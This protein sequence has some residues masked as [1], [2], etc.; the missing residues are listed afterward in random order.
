[1]SQIR[2]AGS[3]RMGYRE[4]DKYGG[5]V[6]KLQSIKRV[7]SKRMGYIEADKY[8]KYVP[9]LSCAGHRNGS[10]NRSKW[11]FYYGLE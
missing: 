6:P 10:I 11:L 5:D 2:N 8:G 1:M 4:R 3:K 7:G 9:G